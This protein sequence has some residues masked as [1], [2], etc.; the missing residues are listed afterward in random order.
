MTFFFFIKFII[1]SNM[2]N[3]IVRTWIRQLNFLYNDNVI[4]VASKTNF[5]LKCIRI[6]T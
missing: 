2:F 4:I 1:L 6:E 5:V 3:T